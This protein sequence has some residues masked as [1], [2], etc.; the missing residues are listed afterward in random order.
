MFCPRCTLSRSGHARCP[1]AYLGAHIRTAGCRS[2][3]ST[4]SSGLN[5]LVDFKIAELQNEIP[6]SSMQMIPEH[7]NV[8]V[9][10][11]SSECG[12]SGDRCAGGGVP[13]HIRENGVK[14][15]QREVMGLV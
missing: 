8:V 9:R 5:S 15:W 14:D 7:T 13:M 2:F 11:E 6:P 10:T 4:T 1:L 12:S 3:A